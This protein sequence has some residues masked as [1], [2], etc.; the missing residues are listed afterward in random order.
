MEWQQPMWQAIFCGKG[1]KFFP[2]FADD[3]V[4]VLQDTRNRY[5]RGSF[6]N[7]IDNSNMASLTN[8]YLENI[9]KKEEKSR[10]ETSHVQKN[11]KKKVKKKKLNYNHREISQQIL[12]ASKLSSAA[13]V[14]ARAHSKLGVLRRSQSTGQYNEREI[15]NA[16]IHARRMVQ[17]ASK[18]VQNLKEEDIQ[19]KKLERKSG[20]EDLVR[21][22][23]TRQKIERKERQIKQE[24]AR[25]Q[26][27][28]AI[29][30]KKDWVELSQKKKWNRN[31]ERG[32]VNEADM[33]YIKGKLA[34]MKDEGYSEDNSEILRLKASLDELNR[35]QARVQAEQSASAAPADS[36]GA[37]DASFS[38][39]LS[40]SA[41][42]QAAAAV[43]STV[44]IAL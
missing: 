2:Y 7:T 30:E 1:T 10:V 37:L 9:K 32:K 4:K 12:R 28:D 13:N 20:G 21:K 33:K 11:S 41:A 5:R 16:I 18:K 24:I 26:A 38:M 40:G 6:M 29:A 35:E 25:Q 14:L 34:I 15:T 42:E 17:C 39:E 22:I 19:K 3:I 23:E 43:G 8:T 31:Q 27:L 44:D 36:S